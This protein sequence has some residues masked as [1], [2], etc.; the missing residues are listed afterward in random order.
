MN[1]MVFHS[2]WKYFMRPIFL[3]LKGNI[4]RN[5]DYRQR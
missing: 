1:H 5:V 4:Y 3:H 2:L